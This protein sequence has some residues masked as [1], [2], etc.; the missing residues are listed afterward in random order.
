MLSTT[1]KIKRS[2]GLGYSRVCKRTDG[3]MRRQ[4]QVYNYLESVS[5]AII[6]KDGSTLSLHLQTAPNSITSRMI[7]EM[8]RVSVLLL[9]QLLRSETLSPFVTRTVVWKQTGGMS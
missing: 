2:R 6:N 1:R 4:G 7:E 3:M 9:F 5:Q 8:K